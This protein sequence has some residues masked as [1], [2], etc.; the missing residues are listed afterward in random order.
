MAPKA[1]LA[2][3]CAANLVVGV[4][5]GV[6]GDRTVFARTRRD[7]NG[8]G[9]RDLSRLV[10]RLDLD[11][12]QQDQVKTILA[13][14][15]ALFS[16]CMKDVKPKLKALREDSDAKIRAVLRPEQVTR[17]DDLR[18]EWETRDR[19]PRDKSSR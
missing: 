5:I 18:R 4:G 14:Q 10:E 6:A 7:R 3:L 8:G 11:A 2:L 9:G 17:L 12:A 19:E 15:R 1:L 13:S 16:D